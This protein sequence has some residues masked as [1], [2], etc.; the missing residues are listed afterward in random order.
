MCPGTG[1]LLAK[2]ILRLL[3]STTNC[4]FFVSFC[5]VSFFSPCGAFNYQIDF[6]LCDRRGKVT[7]CEV[8][9]KADIGL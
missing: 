8:I 9:T 6:A 1:A 5:F 7:N 2:Q 4:L 3:Q